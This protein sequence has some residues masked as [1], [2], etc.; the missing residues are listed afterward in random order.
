MRINR[1]ECSEAGEKYYFKPK[2]LLSGLVSRYGFFV[3]NIDFVLGSSVPCLVPTNLTASNIGYN[4][5]DVT[6]SQPG[7][8]SEWHVQCSANPDFYPLLS[9][10]FVND[11]SFPMTGLDP[12]T[13]Y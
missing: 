3:D 4:G 10:N 5:A 11:A 1:L 9:D 12:G 7:V 6:W 2:L 8:G 13:T